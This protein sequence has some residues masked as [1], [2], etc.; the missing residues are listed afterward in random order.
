MAYK[1]EG[2]LGPWLLTWAQGECKSCTVGWEGL[3][4]PG[5]CNLSSS[6]IVSD[7]S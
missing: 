3:N 5:P 7:D 4:L 1:Q 2:E 6:M